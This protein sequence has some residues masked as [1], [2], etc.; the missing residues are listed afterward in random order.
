MGRVLDLTPPA[1]EGDVI[2]Y[3]TAVERYLYKLTEAVDYELYKMKK[4]AA[5]ATMNTEV[6]ENEL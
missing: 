6:E 2:E 1:F 3:A 5:T 4:A